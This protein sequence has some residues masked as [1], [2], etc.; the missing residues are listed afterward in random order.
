MDQC[1]LL[2]DDE[3]DVEYVFGSETFSVDFFRNENFS[4]FSIHFDSQKCVDDT[5]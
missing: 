3:V 1:D 5:S 4:N 2:V